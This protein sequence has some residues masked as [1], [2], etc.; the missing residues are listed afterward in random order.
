MR[1]S[2]C[3]ARIYMWHEGLAVNWEGY[4]V[5]IQTRVL[6]KQFNINDVNFKCGGFNEIESVFPTV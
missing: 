5:F 2:N 6:K 3:M 1:V 4:N